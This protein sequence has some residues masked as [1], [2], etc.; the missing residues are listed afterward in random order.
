MCSTGFHY[1]DH[2]CGITCFPPNIIMQG[3]KIMP[4]TARVV[5][6]K[7]ARPHSYPWLVNIEQKCGGA[8]IDEYWVLTAAHCL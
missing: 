7:E 4:Y 5:N 6:G 2:P 3:D 8:I 1:E